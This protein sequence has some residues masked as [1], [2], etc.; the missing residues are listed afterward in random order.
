MKTTTSDV[1]SS[2]GAIGS[3][4]IKIIG[5]RG[6]WYT[7]ESSHYEGERVFL[8]EHEQYGDEAAH[9]IVNQDRK[10]IMENVWNGFSDLWEGN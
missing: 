5:H 10:I 3:E 7:L 1:L 6:T 4:G 9:I 2:R 8:L